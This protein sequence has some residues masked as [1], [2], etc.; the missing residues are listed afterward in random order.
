MVITI[1]ATG[2]ATTTTEAALYRL[3][4]W[5]SPAYPL[6]A[7]S[8]SHGLEYAVEAGLVRDAA[9]LSAW[10]ETALAAGA[11]RSDGA[12]LAAAWRAERAKDAAALDELI[13]LATAWRG[14]RETALESEAQ[15]TAFLTTTRAAWPHP[16]LDRLAATGRPIALAIAV[17][18]A[19][20]AHGIPLEP[21]LTAYFHAFAGNLVSAGVRLIPLGQTDGQRVI[22]ALAEP[23]ATAAGAALEAKLDEVGTA[24]PLLDWCSMR[25]ETQYTRLF[26]S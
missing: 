23:V 17:G 14:T 16:S 15:G 12:L 10:V 26:R 8:Y 22:A 7:F 2:M 21:T 3:M 9:G 4:T 25:H 6:G 24:A 11:G 5:L 20:S 13:E 18:S 19:T 1:M